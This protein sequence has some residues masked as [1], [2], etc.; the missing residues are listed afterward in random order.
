MF[1]CSKCRECC[2]N[3]PNISEFKNMHNGNGICKFLKGNFCT[4]YEKRPKLCRVD[5]CYVLF[6]D[7]VS[8]EE[9]LHLNYMSCKILQEKKAQEDL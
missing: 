3:L 4:I 7:V 2:R 8:Y 1:N 5:E 6:K 9:Y